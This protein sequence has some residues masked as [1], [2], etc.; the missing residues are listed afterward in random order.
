MTDP[1]ALAVLRR[2]TEMADWQPRQSPNP[3]AAQGALLIGRGVAYARYKQAENYVA[4]TAEVAVDKNTGK[5][6]VRRITC[7]HDCGLVVNP[8][9][10]RN[11]IEG[12]IIQ[13][14]S[15]AIYEEVKFDQSRVTSVDWITYPI[16]RFPEAPRVDV[17]LIEHPELPLYGAGEAATAPI[18]A[19]IANAVF[20]ASGIRL[21]TAPFTPV[22]VKAAMAAQLKA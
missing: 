10:L 2:A 21:R 19:V 9:A 15:R 13:T 8:N 16:L 22:R 18:A 3:N 20:D 4:L 7:A 12:C 11:Q 6:T 17:A 14:T 1:R 5:I